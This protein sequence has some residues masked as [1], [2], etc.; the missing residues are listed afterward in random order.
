MMYFTPGI[1]FS[2]SFEFYSSG[3]YLQTFPSNESFLNERPKIN[4]MDEVF[5]FWW[6]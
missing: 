3:S 2:A 1:D 5:T 4:D 6:H